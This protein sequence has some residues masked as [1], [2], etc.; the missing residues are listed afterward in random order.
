MRKRFMGAI[1]VLMLLASGCNLGSAE[2]EQDI[3]TQAPATGRPTVTITSPQAGDEFVV[4]EQIFVRIVASD[5][6]GVTRAQL[7]TNGEIVRTISSESINGDI[8]FEG[9]LDY[10]PRTTGEFRLRVLAFRGAI[11]SDPAEIT[12]I[13]REDANEV[14]VTSRPD[15]SGGGTTG[16]TSGQPVIPNDGVCRALTTVGLNLRSEPTTTRDN[17][18][19]VLPSGTLAPIIARLGDNTWWK[20]TYTSR[21]GWVSGDFVTLYGICNAVPVE[22]FV[23]STPTFTPTWTPTVTPL[24]TST[25][26]PTFTPTPGLPD[27]VIATIVGAQNVTIPLGATEVIEEYA[28]TVSNL[29]FGAS[30]Q[31]EVVMRVNGVE[32]DLGVISNLNNG[33]TIVL[34]QDV[35]FNASGF[36]TI[37]VEADPGNAITEISEVNNRGNI[38]VDVVAE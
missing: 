21:V 4:D 33:E 20:L 17:V 18:I 26:V 7:F 24:P 10:T 2:N 13:V 6:V 22:N 31:F 9:V 27:L 25:L 34:T 3:P 23:V 32:I 16:G 12:V 35:T 38:S 15:T 19:T 28:V 37:E 36:Y 29:G 11:A 14:I 5:A 1:G 30:N 8:Q